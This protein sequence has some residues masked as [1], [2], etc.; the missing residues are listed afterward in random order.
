M[1]PGS[2]RR[3][4]KLGSSSSSFS[5]AARSPSPAPLVS[6]A[7]GGA[8]SPSFPAQAE[9]SAATAL[10]VAAAAIL[11]APM[12]ASSS[13]A[14]ATSFAPVVSA[15]ATMRRP[16]T[17]A[18]KAGVMKP[19]RAADFDGP[20]LDGNFCGPAP[21][22]TLTPVALPFVSATKELTASFERT[23]SG[24]VGLGWLAMGAPA[25]FRRGAPSCRRLSTG[26]S[27]EKNGPEDEV[28]LGPPEEPPP[29]RASES[30]GSRT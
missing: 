10:G 23:F 18:C 6:V 27:K 9:V 29:P 2:T 19:T 1:L 8:V 5:S 14:S 3:R 11:P 7:C 12:A 15:D 4:L 20:G 21:T 16:K 25:E 28:L 24:G 17:F 30:V 26:A 13:V 22:A